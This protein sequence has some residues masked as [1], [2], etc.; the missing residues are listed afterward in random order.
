[1]RFIWRDRRGEAHVREPASRIAWMEAVA[2]AALS[3]GMVPVLGAP[4]RKSSAPMA[5]LLANFRR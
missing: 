1:M 3:H 2:E 4:V 5:R